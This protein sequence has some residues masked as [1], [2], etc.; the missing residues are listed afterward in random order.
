MKW[1]ALENDGFYAAL[2]VGSVR[3]LILLKLCQMIFDDVFA[4]DTSNRWEHLD[5]SNTA[6]PSFS[7][8]EMPRLTSWKSST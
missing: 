8:R 7:K 1:K 6:N 3:K 5:S 4:A 2:H